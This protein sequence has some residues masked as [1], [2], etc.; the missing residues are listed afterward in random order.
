[1]IYE[2]KDWKSV[3]DRVVSKSGTIESTMYCVY[4]EFGGK[5][6]R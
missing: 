4:E 2:S 5:M 3:R 6:G 1:M